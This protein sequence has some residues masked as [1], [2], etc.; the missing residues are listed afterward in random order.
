MNAQRERGPLLASASD[1][2][3]TRRAIKGNTVVNVA[4][5]PTAALNLTNRS[6]NRFGISTAV[7]RKI[8]VANL[9]A[10]DPSNGMALAE[11]P[12]GSES[13]YG[14]PFG[15]DP[16]SPHITFSTA[17]APL[18]WNNRILIATSDLELFLVDPR[19]LRL[20]EHGRLLADRLMVGGH[21]YLI[22]DLLILVG[23]SLWVVDVP[24]WRLMTTY[25]LP[26]IPEGNWLLAGADTAQRT[27][28]LIN[29]KE[30]CLRHLDL[31]SG[32]LSAPRHCNLAVDYPA[33][34]FGWP[35]FAFGAP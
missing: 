11:L 34:L 33:P 30:G 4:E 7:A 9:V 17:L 16:S 10:L 19:S 25:P 14:K 8:T 26:T 35:A 12:L 3:V 15:E 29:T 2:Y 27:A 1:C 5:A 13:R 20:V 18:L 31:S 23:E 24:N 6:R 22:G 21:P 28:F 32:D